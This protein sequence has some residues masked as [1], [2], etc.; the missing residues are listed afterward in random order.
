M[1]VSDSKDKPMILFCIVEFQGSRTKPIEMASQVWLSKDEK[2]IW[3][4]PIK[5]TR[6]SVKFERTVREHCTTTRDWKVEEIRI[7]YQHGM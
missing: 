7:L 4:P 6:D 5:V 3:W 2:S 1:S